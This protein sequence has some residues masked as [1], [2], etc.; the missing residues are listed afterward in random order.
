MLD[1][2][3]WVYELI[4]QTCSY[5]SQFGLL[6][7][8]VVE[9]LILMKRNLSSVS[10][11]TE[12]LKRHFCAFGD[13]SSTS[14]AEVRCRSIDTLDTY[15]DA[16]LKKR[17]SPV[18]SLWLWRMNSFERSALLRSA[19]VTE[20]KPD[21]FPPIFILSHPPISRFFLFFARSFSCADFC[22]SSIYSL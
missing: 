19:F 7:S 11:R 14:A 20:N 16:I 8:N 4:W 13:R 9:L 18:R 10:N 6:M 5:I 2:N 12:Y 22:L 21:T 1:I 3:L 17:A 15:V